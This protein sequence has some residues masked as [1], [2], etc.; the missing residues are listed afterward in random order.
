MFIDILNTF[1]FLC[2][3]VFAYLNLNDKDSWLWVSIY[4][5]TALLCILTVMDFYFPILYILL[6]LFYLTYALVLFFI[7]DGVKDWLTKYNTENIAQSMQAK[8]PYIEKARE[9]FG[10][11]IISFALMLN[12]LLL[13]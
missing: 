12:Y 9:F 2:F 11:L 4:M 6:T 13:S 8:K 1:F 5:V 10:L 7:K 3:T